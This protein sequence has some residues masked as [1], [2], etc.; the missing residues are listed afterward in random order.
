M[1]KLSEV[2]IEPVLVHESAVVDYTLFKIN[3]D[4]FSYSSCS[5]RDFAI[6]DFFTNFIVLISLLKFTFRDNRRKTFLKFVTI[7][8]ILFFMNL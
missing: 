7:N 1:T 4:F 2:I 8:L 3:L 5:R 6:Y